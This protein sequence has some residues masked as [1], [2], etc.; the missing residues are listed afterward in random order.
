MNIFQKL[1]AIQI[2]LVAKKD[3]WNAFSKYQYRSA[4]GVI[5]SLK[6]HL[7]KHELLLY[8]TNEVVLIGNNYYTK[9][10]VFLQDVS[11]K[12]TEKDY[13]KCQSLARESDVLK[14]Q[15]SAQISGGTQSYAFKYALNSMFLIDDG[16][17]DADSQNTR[18]D[19]EVKPETLSGYLKQ[20]GVSAKEFVSYYM[21]QATQAKELLL[22]KTQL[23]K[24]ILEFTSLS[25]Q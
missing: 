14:G 11:E 6:P 16:N 3:K 18:E 5:E 21:I 9:V 13:L 2:E 22:N 7:K 24:M 19:M 4:E 8:S 23:D 10:T 15:I 1:A 20:S 25:K 12:A 17:G